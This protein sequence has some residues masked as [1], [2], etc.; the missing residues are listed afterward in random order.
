MRPFERTRGRPRRRTTRRLRSPRTSWSRSRSRRP[1]LLAEA[2]VDEPSRGARAAR[3]ADRGQL[4]R[5]RC[6]MRSPGRSPAATRRPSHATSA[7][8]ARDARP[9]LCPST[10]RSPSAPGSSRRGRADERSPAPRPS[11]AT[12]LA[13]ARRGVRASASCRRWARSTMAT[14]SL[15]RAARER[16]DLVVMS[17]FVN[18]AQFGPGED[19][20]ELPARRGRA[21][22]TWPR[23]RRRHRLRARRPARSTRTG[24][25]RASRSRR[26]HRRSS[27][28]TRPG[29]APE[30]LPRRHHGRRQAAQR[31]RSGRRLLR[32]EGRPAGAGDPAHGAGPRLPGRGRDAPDRARAGRPRDELPQR[33]PRQRASATAPRRFAG[34]CAPPPSAPPPGDQRR[35]ARSRRPRAVLDAAPGSSPS[36][37]RRATP[38]T[39][40]RCRASTDG[41]CWWP[42]PRGSAGPG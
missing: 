23:G 34:H 30:P 21:T 1:T 16:C 5:R 15:L 19:L 2:G 22:S 27:T 37:S 20:D 13:P 29:G 24:S 17:L 10:R 4:G 32:A 26:P 39:S 7:R 14:S 6:G 31:R 11:C 25:R 35:R 40:G 42:S 9:E 8:S 33:L 18:P 36:T 3:P 12:A 28:A 41:P 38:R